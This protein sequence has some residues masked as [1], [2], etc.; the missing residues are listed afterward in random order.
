MNAIIKAL[1]AGDYYCSTGPEI[2]DLYLE[3]G[4]AVPGLLAGAPH[5]A[6]VQGHRLRRRPLRRGRLPDPFRMG[7]PADAAE[8]FG[9]LRFVLTDSQGAGRSPIPI[10]R[11]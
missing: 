2:H 6:A 4:P 8:R 3:D 10:I 1:D 11:A 5:R 9:F 7:D